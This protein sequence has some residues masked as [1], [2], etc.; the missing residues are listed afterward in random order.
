MNAAPRRDPF[1]GE[2]FEAVSR[3]TARSARRGEIVFVELHGERSDFVRVNHA[4]V[5]QAGSVE[6][7][8]A[9]VRLI[10]ERRQAR[11]HCTLASP[12]RVGATLRDALAVLRETIASLPADPHAL[13]AHA[14]STSDRVSGG[15][16]AAPDDALG[17]IVD[18]AGGDDLVGSYAAG[19]IVRALA[20][21]LGHAHYH[22]S[23]CAHFDFSIHLDG[24]RAVKETW[25][26]AHWDPPVLRAA[27]ASARER[28]RVLRMR[29]RRV[30][31]GAWRVLLSSRAVADLVGLLGWGGFSERASRS[32][33]SPLAMAQRGEAVFDPSFEIVEDVDAL[34]VPRFQSEGFERPARLALIRAGRPAHRLVSPRSAMEFGVDANGSD[35]DERPLAACVAP[36]RLADREALATLDTGLVVEN[37]W[38]LNYSD[39][40]ACR[41]TGMTRFATL[42]VHDGEA[43]APVEPMRFDDSLYRVFGSQLV[44][45]TDTVRRMPTIETW[46]GR[47]PGGV[48]APAALVDGLRLT[49]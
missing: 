20:S 23:R 33:Q 13:W 43:V 46:E 38:Y 4:R 32:G 1:F 14:P 10:H 29:P 48:G 44:A 35:G 34:G 8:V 30:D 9:V 16:A 26:S 21:S 6:R 36:G 17:V 25:A 37:L 5:R 2:V 15:E 12:R 28:A 47:E 31:P 3:W 24:A 39:R 42:W 19:P 7:A 49:S 18:S 11:M 22:E 45:L 27:I 41:A 40:H